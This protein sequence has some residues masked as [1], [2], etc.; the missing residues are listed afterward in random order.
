MAD[1]NLTHPELKEGEIFV[2]N[3]NTDKLSTIGWK[4]KRVGIIAYDIQGKEI[5]WLVPV[6][7]QS[8]EKPCLFD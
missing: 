5:N 7:R 3:S 4:T 1:F 2:T 8:S 6:F